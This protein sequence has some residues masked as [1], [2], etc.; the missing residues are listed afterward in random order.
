MVALCL[1]RVL[2]NALLSLMLADF[3]SLDAPKR[4][5]DETSEMSKGVAKSCARLQ[6]DI[7]GIVGIVGEERLVVRCERKGMRLGSMLLFIVLSAPLHCSVNAGKDAARLT[8]KDRNL[9]M[10]ASSVCSYSLSRWFICL[11]SCASA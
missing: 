7:C 8:E 9:A 4:D 5:A 2:D 1:E 3:L 6:S 10:T 11:F